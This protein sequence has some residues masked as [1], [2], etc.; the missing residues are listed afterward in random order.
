[1]K[2]I[3]TLFVVIFQMTFV[4]PQ[5]QPQIPEEIAKNPE[6]NKI[7]TTITDDL[8]KYWQDM[9]ISYGRLMSDS[10][11]TEVEKKV[12][13]Q[14]FG[15]RQHEEI[16]GR[17]VNYIE[18][19]INNPVGGHLLSSYYM[20]MPIDK[21]GEL[22]QKMPETLVKGKV[23]EV[24]NYVDVVMRTSPGQLFID[25]AMPT[26]EGK[27]VKLSEEIKRNKMTLIDFWASWC[28]PC[29]AEMPHVIKAYEQ[30]KDKG[31]GIVGVSLDDKAERWTK[32]IADWGMPWTH[33]SDLK[34][35][36]CEGAA[37]YGVHAIPASY[38]IGQDGKIIAV[39]L[40]GED[41]SKKLSELLDL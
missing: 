3:I 36:K 24:R 27:T 11:L 35:W 38:L 32:A 22:L 25:F 20:N 31:F 40:R 2:K 15:I 9:Q 23:I 16:T 28:G 39:N 7:L 29:K 14:E 33:I 26:P 30:F 19:N 5:Q 34:G 13:S 18:E 6:W 1:M 37:L 4:F 8:T 12:K 41:L 17:I 10:S 21:V